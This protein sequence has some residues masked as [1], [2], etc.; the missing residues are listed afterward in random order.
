VRAARSKGN[1]RPNIHSL[2]LGSYRLPSGKCLNLENECTI[3]I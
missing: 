1:F 2:E 3:L